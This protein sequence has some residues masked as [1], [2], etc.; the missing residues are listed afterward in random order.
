[1]FVFSPIF[2]TLLIKYRRDIKIWILM[3]ILNF[4]LALLWKQDL[5]HLVCFGCNWHV[6]VWFVLLYGMTTDRV[7]CQWQIIRKPRYYFF[8]LKKLL[9]RNTSLTDHT[10]YTDTGENLGTVLLRRKKGFTYI[11]ASKSKSAKHDLLPI[12]TC[13]TRN[14]ATSNRNLII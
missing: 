13:R 2:Y 1:M 6:F 4:F 14:S 11:K 7:V 9:I 12:L 8:I 3:R 10:E 5:F